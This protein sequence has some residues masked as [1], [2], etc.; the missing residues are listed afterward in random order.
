MSTVLSILF[1]IFLLIILPVMI[2]DWATASDTE[3]ARRWRQMGW[4]QQQI[5]DRLGVSRYRVRKMLAA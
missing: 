4:T 2:L 5:A 3:R 1:A